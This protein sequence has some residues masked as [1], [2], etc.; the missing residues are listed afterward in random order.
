MTKIPW[1]GSG[2]WRIWKQHPKKERKKKFNRIHHKI[3]TIFFYWIQQKK[4][5]IRLKS[6]T[7]CNTNSKLGSLQDSG[8]PKLFVRKSYLHDPVDLFIYLFIYLFLQKIIFVKFSWPEFF[9]VCAWLKS[10]NDGYGFTR[11]TT[12]SQVNLTIEGTSWFVILFFV[13]YST[14]FI[15]H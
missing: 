5:K 11:I 13:L 14:E 8:Y 7:S 4:K 3:R 1:Y 12:S 2:E 6:V 9:F 15:N 10:K